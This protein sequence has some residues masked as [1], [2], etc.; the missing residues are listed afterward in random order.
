MVSHAQ[1]PIILYCDN[2]G[3]VAQS[4]DSRNHNSGKHIERKYLLIRKI[5]QHGDVIATNVTSTNNLADPFTKALTY[6]VFRFHV[7]R[8]VVRYGIL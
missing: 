1:L 7:D 6:N 3:V 2:N 4:K 8:M 5:V